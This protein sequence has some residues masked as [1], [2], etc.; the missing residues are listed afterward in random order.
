MWKAVT[1]GTVG[2]P[3]LFAKN[4]M[5]IAMPPGNPAGV[6]SLQSLQTRQ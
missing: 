1:A 5:A 3:L 6:T 4:T 2:R